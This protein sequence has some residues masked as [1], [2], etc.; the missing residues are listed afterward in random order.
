MEKALLSPPPPILRINRVCLNPHDSKWFNRDRLVLSAGHGSMMLYSFL[1]LTGY[2]D[3]PLNDIKNFRQL[4][5]KAAGHPENHL[6]EAIETKYNIDFQGLFLTNKRFTNCFLECKNGDKPQAD[7]EV[8]I[9]DWDELATQEEDGGMNGASFGFINGSW[10]T[11]LNQLTYGHHPTFSLGSEHILTIRVSVIE[12]TAL[13]T[14]DVY[15]NGAYI[16][17]GK[18]PFKPLECGHRTYL[19][20][21]AAR[22]KHFRKTGVIVCTFPIGMTTKNDKL[23]ISYGDNDSCVKIME[24]TIDEMKKTMSKIGY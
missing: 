12:P 9:V 6:F 17:E 16:F 24:T 19:R 22:E 13:F 7:N 4:Y 10:D 1:Y 18:P 3:F 5:S 8:R 14:V 21:E 23:I 2:K 20:A 15:D 11:P